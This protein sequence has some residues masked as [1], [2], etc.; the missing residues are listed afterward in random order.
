MAQVKPIT[1]TQLLAVIS[2]VV[3]PLIGWGYSVES[4]KEQTLENTLRI[5]ENETA[6]RGIELELNKSRVESVENHRET[7]ENQLEIMELLNKK[8]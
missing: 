3:L 2:V 1:F 6:I 5:K 7:V 8:K 4:A